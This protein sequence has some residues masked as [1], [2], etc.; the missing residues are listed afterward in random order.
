MIE[1][2]ILGNIS[3]DC[4][5]PEKQRDFYAELTGWDR[6]IQW[7]CPALVGENGL[8]TVLF[9]GCD[10][11]YAPPV[12]PEE[13][14][15]Q[16]K[17]M[18]FDFQVKDLAAAV[19]AAIA[20]GAVKPASQY[21][22]E[23]FVTLLDPEGHPFCLCRAG[24]HM[25]IKLGTF[26]ELQDV[27]MPLRHAVFYDEQG[28]PRGVMDDEYNELATQCA[29]FDGGRLVSTARLAEIDGICVIGQ[30]VTLKSERGKGYG[31]AAV[32]ALIELAKERGAAEILVHAQTQAAEFYRGLGFA[33][34]G[35]PY[36]EGEFELV[37]MKII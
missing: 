37:D 35:Q 15:K 23:D 5:E 4:K 11:D 36:C 34:C 17:Q 3:I 2:I 8:L 25:R 13:N 7:D 28:I 18:H 21:G 27:V 24:E 33:V 31:K 12:W 29:V 10:F 9:M 22:G 32:T 1:G 16:Q 26:A 14:G 30:V 19:D 20:L 6:R